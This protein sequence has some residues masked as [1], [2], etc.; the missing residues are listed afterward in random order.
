MRHLKN[1]LWNVELVDL[2]HN[3]LVL[4][5]SCGAC[6]GADSLG[7]TTLLTDDPAHIA[8]GNMD[9]VYGGTLLVRFVNGYAD[10]LGLFNQALC[11]SKK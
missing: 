3:L 1:V 2:Y 9:V 6:N 5:D 10:S 8:L 4:A 11:N 7:Y